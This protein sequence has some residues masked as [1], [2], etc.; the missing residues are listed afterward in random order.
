MSAP[1]AAR[2][3]C[4][5]FFTFYGQ[6][7]SYLRDQVRAVPAAGAIYSAALHAD[8]LEPGT[9]H[10]LAVAA[11]NLLA[12]VGSTDWPTDGAPTDTQPVAV[13]EACTRLG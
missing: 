6:W 12:Y 2:L 9:C 13:E 10:H 7:A 4:N 11:G 3:A 1:A 8:H 5:E